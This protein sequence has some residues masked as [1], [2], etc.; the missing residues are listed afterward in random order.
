MNTTELPTALAVPPRA[1]AAL[2]SI[3]TTK[4]Q[5]LLASG[6]LSSFRIGAARRIST[7]SIREY[8]ARQIAAAHGEVGAQHV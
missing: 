7:D 5:E 3:G 1:A 6:E 2:L 8:V 4:L